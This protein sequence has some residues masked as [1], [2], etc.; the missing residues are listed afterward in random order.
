MER[1]LM[2]LDGCLFNWTEEPGHQE[3]GSLVFDE[4]GSK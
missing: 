4:I 3:S 1:L 2:A